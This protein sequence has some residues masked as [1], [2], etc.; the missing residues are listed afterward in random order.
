LINTDNSKTAKAERFFGTSKIEKE[1]KMFVKDLVLTEPI[2]CLI[3]DYLQKSARLISENNLICLPVFES[4]AHKNVIG[5][6]TE[7]VICQASAS[8]LD[9][10]QT[11]VGRILSNRYFIVT[12]ETEIEECRR[13]MKENEIDFLFVT[14][15]DNSCSGIITKN[16]LSEKTSNFQPREMQIQYARTDRLF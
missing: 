1:K 4:P 3:D 7:K 8:G 9:P 16:L 14:E 11:K 5:V 2:Y 15:F 13:I 10:Q 12:P 6:V